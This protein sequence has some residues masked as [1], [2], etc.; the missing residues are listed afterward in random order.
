MQIHRLHSESLR[1]PIDLGILLNVLKDRPKPGE[2]G[3]SIK[4]DFTKLVTLVP[5][6]K[7]T[8]T[9]A[10]EDRMMEAR[11]HI[12]HNCYSLSKT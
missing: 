4:P 5:G 7:R 3:Q 6:L 12:P 8:R 2:A 10:E 11:G 9:F 1:P